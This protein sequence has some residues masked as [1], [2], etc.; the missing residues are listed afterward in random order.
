MASS[1]PGNFHPGI[2]NHHAHIYT[3][4]STYVVYHFFSNLHTVN[5]T[6]KYC[7][8]FMSPFMLNIFQISFIAPPSFEKGL[9]LG[10]MLM[11]NHDIFSGQIGGVE[12]YSGFTADVTLCSFVC[13]YRNDYVLE[14]TQ[15]HTQVKCCFWKK[16][17][18]TLYLL[19][20]TFTGWLSVLTCW[21][22]CPHP[23]RLYGS[24]GPED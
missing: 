12:T 14:T 22:G 15:N 23:Y 7:G 19:S 11:T 21:S 3:R 4:S 16:L 24:M 17:L 18:I 8:I 10:S 20:Q 9:V 13:H 5:V 6:S 2:S 1:K